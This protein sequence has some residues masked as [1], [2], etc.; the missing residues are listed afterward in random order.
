R[1]RGGAMEP[2]MSFWDKLKPAVPAAPA[3]IGTD[4]TSDGKVLRLHWEDGKRTASTARA[5]RLACPCAAC[6]DEWTSAKTLDP[7]SVPETLTIREVAP[8]GNYALRINFSDH[9]ATGI[10]PWTVL[11]EVT[12]RTPAPS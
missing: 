2:R 1:D 8:V 6:V 9:H 12:E 4:V 5:L 7:A 3:A 11:R 10:Y